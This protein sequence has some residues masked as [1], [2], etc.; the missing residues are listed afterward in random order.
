MSQA[1]LKKRENNGVCVN[2]KKRQK[3]KKRI[4]V[5][6]RKYS[7]TREIHV[8]IYG[9]PAAGSARDSGRLAC[10]IS[11]KLFSACKAT[12]KGSSGMTLTDILAAKIERS[13]N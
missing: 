10:T 6:K 13:K 7:R 9:V 8:K 1:D 11:D 12:W 3:K 5:E 2:Q 4:K